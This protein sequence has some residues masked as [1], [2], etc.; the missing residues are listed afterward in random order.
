LT[1]TS[2]IGLLAGI[3]LAGLAFF[4]HPGA[5]DTQVFVL[6]VVL[7]LAGFVV[8]AAAASVHPALPGGAVGVV[9][10]VAVLGTATASLS[11]T[12]TAPPLGYGNAN[13]A[14]LLCGTAGLV[15]CVP[16]AP[17]AWRLPAALAALVTAVLCVLTG[18]IASTIGCVLLVGFMAVR[19]V[20]P[21]WLWQVVAGVLIAVP[22]TMT[23]LW[24]SG[25]VHPPGWALDALTSQRLALWSDAVDL[26]R[27]FPVIGAGPGEFALRSATARGDADLVW[28]HSEPL[29]VA[30]ELGLVG[31][32]LLTVML[33]CGI[34]LLRRDAVILA[35]LLLPAAVDYV[36]HFGWVLA[37]YAVVLGGVYAGS[38]ASVASDSFGMGKPVLTPP[39][40]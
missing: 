1:A 6:S 23:A 2:S 34:V 15:C 13:G 12:P 32:V 16:R 9:V 30:A 26:V 20:G 3:G 33:V 8:G 39:S 37:A 27:R 17:E 24:G 28:A 29:Q 4:A 31:A 14:F 7:V 19:R 22:I 35:V 36:F 10:L 21:A 11:G 18:S 25:V 5:P 40:P 38:S